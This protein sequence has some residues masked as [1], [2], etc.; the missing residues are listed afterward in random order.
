MNKEKIQHY[1]NL[2]DYQNKNFLNGAV[3]QFINKRNMKN[4]KRTYSK[5]GSP[6]N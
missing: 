1:E 2:D 4:V 5:R 3:N 6:E